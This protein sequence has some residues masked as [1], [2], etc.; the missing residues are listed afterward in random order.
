MFLQNHNCVSIMVD[1]NQ[2]AHS[3]L[4]KI[5]MFPTQWKISKYS[6]TAN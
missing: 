6:I 2:I 1:T 3:N 4:I 5:R